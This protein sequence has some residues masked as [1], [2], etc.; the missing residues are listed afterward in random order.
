MGFLKQLCS[1]VVLY[2]YICPS[3]QEFAGVYDESH[4]LI[5]SYCIYSGLHSSP[6]KTNL[7]SKKNDLR[8]L[9]DKPENCKFSVIILSV[10]PANQNYLTSHDKVEGKTETPF[11]VREK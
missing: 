9:Q 5:Y 3:C 6:S 1:T 2:I 8:I 4:F 10:P 7:S 11:T